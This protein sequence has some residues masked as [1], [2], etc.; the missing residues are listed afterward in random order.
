[1]SSCL[2]SNV[3]KSNTVHKI[4]RYKNNSNTNTKPATYDLLS[5]DACHQYQRQDHCLYP[6]HWIGC[7]NHYHPFW[8]NNIIYFHTALMIRI[9]LAFGHIKCWWCNQTSHS[10]W[11]IHSTLNQGLTEVTTDH[12]RPLISSPYKLNKQ[13]EQSGLIYQHKVNVYQL[14]M[15]FIWMILKAQMLVRLWP[16]QATN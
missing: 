15:N 3:H 12:H 2:V 8:H 10:Q 7:M 16:V 6:R 14:L 11:F 1:M 5:E 4:L 13:V 9:W